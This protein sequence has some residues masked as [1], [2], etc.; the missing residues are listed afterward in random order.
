MSF[1]NCFIFGYGDVAKALG[2]SLMEKGGRVAG[3]SR[4][5][6]TVSKLKQD[7]VHACHYMDKKS[8]ENT[9]KEYNN[10]LI[11]I[12]P[13]LDGDFV[14]R[15][16]KDY[17][18]GKRWIGY[19]S[20]TSVYGDYGGDWVDELDPTR[21]KMEKAK[22]R[23]KAENQWLNTGEM[24]HI[25]RLAAIYSEDR[26]LITPTLKGDLKRIDKKNHYFSRIHRDDI[27]KILLRSMEIPHKG[28]IYNV[29]D[30]HPAPMKEVIEFI[31]DELKLDYPDLI[32]FEDIKDLPRGK[33]DYFKESKRVNNIRIKEELR[34]K[35]KYPS[36]KDGLK[37][38]LEKMKGISLL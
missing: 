28:R 2:R 6:E 27:V 23:Q 4:S 12:P 8:I 3:T 30:D 21:A 35:L 7:G 16:Y 31:C 29:A 24:I 11:S 18:L 13:D 26:N 9:I 25:F 15:D 19:L 1:D 38:I 22:N 5:P 10:V 20:T 17:C 14:Y 36:Y 37:A 32:N 34:I 33:A